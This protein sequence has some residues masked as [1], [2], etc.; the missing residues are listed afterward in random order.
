MGVGDGANP[1]LPVPDASDARGR[2][3]HDARRPAVCSVNDPPLPG[4]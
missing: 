1:G 4:P 2:G 3:T